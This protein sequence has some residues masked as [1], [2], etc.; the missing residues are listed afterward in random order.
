MTNPQPSPWSEVRFCFPRYNRWLA[1][2]LRPFMG[3][4]VPVTYDDWRPGDQ[5]VYVSDTSKARQDL[6]WQPAVDRERGV[7]KL[8]SWVMENKGL[9][10][11]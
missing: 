9:F 8:H 1:N 7:E 2:R 3:H 4:R 11:A 6:G 5:P 10:G